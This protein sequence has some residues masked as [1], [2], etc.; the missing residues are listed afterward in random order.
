[1]SQSNT[2]ATILLELP[3]T[4]FVLKNNANKQI[5]TFFFT[6]LCFIQIYAYDPNYYQ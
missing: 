3:L 6:I 5:L 1:M 2:L 4:V